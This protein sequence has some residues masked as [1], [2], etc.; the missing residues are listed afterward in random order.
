MA[1]TVEDEHCYQHVLR[2]ALIAFIKG[3]PPIMAV[4]VARRAVPGR[5]RP[6][7]MELEKLC[8]GGG[9]EAAAVP[10]GGAAAEAAAAPAS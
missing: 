1:K 3:T 9:G 6:S 10:E 4:E 7:F 5:V 2:I 8:R